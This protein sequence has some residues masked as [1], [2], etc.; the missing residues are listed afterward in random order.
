MGASRKS[1]TRSAREKE[2]ERLEG[3]AE[4]SRVVC[5][6]AAHEGM[7][8]GGGGGG[9]GQSER[10]VWR[11][12]CEGKEEGGEEEEEGEEKTLGLSGRGQWMSFEE[13]VCRD[14]EHALQILRL[15]GIATY[16]CM[17]MYVY[18]CIYVSEICI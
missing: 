15:Q 10:M 5:W 9:G 7:G 6:Q 14:K 11:G 17:I 16:L 2:R 3:A 18:I 4:F 13:L 12:G 8:E 1:V